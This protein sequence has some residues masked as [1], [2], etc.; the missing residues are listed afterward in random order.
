[1]G[2]VRRTGVHG[3]VEQ[4]HRVT[5][6]R[7][8]GGTGNFDQEMTLKELGCTKGATS[9]TRHAHLNQNA[10][11]LR[12]TTLHSFPVQ[13]PANCNPRPHGQSPQNAQRSKL[14]PPRREGWGTIRSDP[15]LNFASV[16][17]A[18]WNS[19][20]IDNPPPWGGCAWGR[21]GCPVG[22]GGT[23]QALRHLQTFVPCAQSI[24]ASFGM[25][26]SYYTGNQC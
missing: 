19:G 9:Q 7:D 22:G 1:M 18:P 5:I 12:N 23:W 21:G 15:N 20:T 26:S 6:R 4:V 17:L 14:L 25:H 3:G 24:A 10:A 2:A 8:H 11:L 16:P 13:A